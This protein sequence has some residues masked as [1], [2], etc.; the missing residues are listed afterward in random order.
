MGR[1][2]QTPEAETGGSGNPYYLSSQFTLAPHVSC[3]IDAALQHTVMQVKQNAGTVAGPSFGW[4]RIDSLA[5]G[6]LSEK[7]S[8]SF[9]TQRKRRATP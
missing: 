2:A 6:W 7:V 1:L 3:A 4:V 8:I 9:E 5:P